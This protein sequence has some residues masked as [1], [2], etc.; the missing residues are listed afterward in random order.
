MPYPRAF[1]YMLAVIGIIVIGFWPTI[2]R[3]V[4]RPFAVAVSRAWHSGE[5]PWVLTVTARS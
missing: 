3:P 1:Y 5:P 4:R 2:L